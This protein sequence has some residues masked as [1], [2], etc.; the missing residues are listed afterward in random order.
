MKG[1]LIRSIFWAMLALF[2]VT[3]TTMFTVVYLADDF[4]IGYIVIPV[5]VIFAGLGATLIVLTLKQKVEG[6]L[7][8]FL[9][10]AGSSAAGFA[11]FVLFHNIVSGLF[12]I[13]EA[14]FFILATIVC[15]LG[16]LVGTIGTIALTIRNKPTAPTGTS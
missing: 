14:V 1:R 3:I 10:L 2:V 11:V 7:K 6:V 4:P 9:L 12:N 5:W 13:E 16:F 15:P 8:H